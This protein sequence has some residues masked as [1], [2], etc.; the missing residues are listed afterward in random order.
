M[1]SKTVGTLLSIFGIITLIIC[2]LILSTISDSSMIVFGVCGA[3]FGIAMLVFGCILIYGCFV[4][5]Q[6]KCS[7]SNSGTLTF[8]NRNPAIAKVV[9]I[10]TD[11][12]AIV[13]YEPVKIHIGAATVGGITTGGAYTT[14]GYNYLAGTKENG[15]Y[16]LTAN[17]QTIFRIQLSETQYLSAKNSNIAKYLNENYQIQ[18][19]ENAKLTSDDVKSAFQSLKQTDFL[20]GGDAIK[21]GYPSYGKC[22]EILDWLCGKETKN[23]KD[24]ERE[25]SKNEWKC[26]N[27]GKIHQNYV[28]SCECGEMK[29]R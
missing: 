1:N 5:E 7:I 4:A 27:C 22:V 8:T 17:N 25:P 21:N 12:D 20:Y 14:G 16:K 29:P 13:K 19:I 26:P 18:V 24:F 6:A 9:K 23:E 15:K 11:S 28:G 2:I 3:I 10:K